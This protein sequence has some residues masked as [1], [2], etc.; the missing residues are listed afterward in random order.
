MSYKV[1]IK[2]FF[3]KSKYMIMYSL[4][5]ITFWYVLFFQV[6][7]VGYSTYYEKK[8]PDIEI[9]GENAENNYMLYN[10][11][12]ASAA[13]KL[14]EEGVKVYGMTVRNL[15]TFSDAFYQVSYRI[16]GAEELFINELEHY[17]KRGEL[18]FEGKTEAVIGS[19]VA[20]FYQVKVGDVLDMPIT[21]DEDT[22]HADQKYT[23]SGILADDAHFFQDGIYISKATCE[24]AGGTAVDNTLYVYGGNQKSCERILGQLKEREEQLR[25]GGVTGHFINKGSLSETIRDA[26]LKTIP[27]SAVVLS[28]IF[29][30][31]LK[32]TGRKI[33]LMKALGVSDRHLMRLLMKGFGVYNLA[34]ML[35][36][37]LSLIF[38]RVGFG[39]PL[40]APVILYS[41]YSFAVIFA[42]TIAILFI[43]CKKISPRLAMYR[44]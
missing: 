25:V 40:P 41:V 6:A 34:G 2:V 31:L 33:G 27:L 13:A 17:L 20:K 12:D 29:M 14:K 36:S 15:Y 26:L 18:P 19:N 8:I 30:S 7:S 24:K 37:Y 39:V 11:L 5:I 4:S 42:V 43:L 3:E 32:Y 38:V 9:Y 23:V 1:F 22:G 16:Y 44:Y 35:L 21:L 10:S 28:A